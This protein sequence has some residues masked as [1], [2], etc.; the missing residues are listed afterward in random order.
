MEEQIFKIKFELFGVKKVA[1]IKAKTLEEAKVKLNAGI[2]AK[3]NI[4]STEYKEPSA[5]A[6]AE[7]MF[8][9]FQEMFSNIDFFGKKR[10]HP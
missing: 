1:N 7:D 3:V 8:G 10:T 5:K 2:V 9:K 6:V 4:L